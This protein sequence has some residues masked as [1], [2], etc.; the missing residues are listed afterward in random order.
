MKF[1]GAAIAEPSS[2]DRVVDII[3]CQMAF[4]KKIAIVVS[5]MGNTTDDLFELAYKVNPNPP[6]RELD[7]L[8]TVGERISISLLAMALAKRGINAKSF[9]GSQSGIVTSSDHNDA[10]IL[11]VLPHRLNQAFE[12][13][14]VVIVAGFQGVSTDG[15]ITTLGR[16][17]SD[18]T[19]VALAA[20]LGANFLEFYKNVSGVFNK[21]PNMCSSAKKYTQL[22]HDEAYDLVIQGAKI[23]HPHC[24]LLAKEKGMTLYVK[25]FLH[26]KEQGTKITTLA[27]LE[28]PSSYEATP[29]GSYV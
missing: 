9:T 21:D 16:G 12:E 6:K 10:K 1:G 5:A 15:E 7:M 22:T 4:F 18:T 3:A 19:A 28:G 11:H 17:G 24:I 13:G 23:L 14:H 29:L 20:A 8:V 26:P 2:F 27:M 25:S